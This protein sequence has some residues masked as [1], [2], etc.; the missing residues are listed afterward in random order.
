MAIQRLLRAIFSFFFGFFVISAGAATPPPASSPAPAADS[1]PEC[2]IRSGTPVDWPVAVTDAHGAALPG[3]RVRLSCGSLTTLAV[4]G[5]DGVARL[6]V[7]PGSYR[8]TAEAPGFDAASQPVAV[9]ASPAEPASIRLAVAGA[10]ST[11]EVRADSGY[12]AFS[13]ETGSKS[14]APLIEVPQSISVINTQEMKAR[15][16][17]SV[18]DAVRYTPGVVA[19]EYGVELRYDWMKVRGFTVDQTGV[20]RDGMHWN[21]LAGKLDPYQLESIEI[22]KGPASVLYGEA[23]PGGLINLDTKRPPSEPLHEFRADFGSYDRRQGAL[24]FGGP[25]VGSL[26][27]RLT[28]LVRNSGT[29]I[30]YTPDNRRLAA[31]ALTWRPSD[32]TN[33]TLLGDWQHDK[34]RWS[35]FLPASGTLYH[36][37][38]NGVI[39]VNRFVGE[40]GWEKVIRDQGSIGWMADHSF[41]DGW[42]VHQNYRFQHVNFKGNTVYGVGYDPGSDRLLDRYAYDYPQL[43]DI[44]TVD[45]RATRRFVLGPTEHNFLG[46]YDYT[47]LRTITWGSFAVAPTIDV[48]APVYGAAIPALTPSQYTNLLLEQHGGYLQDQVKVKRRL[49][50]TLG[51]REDW[52][53]DDTVDHLASTSLHQNDSKFTG[54]AGAT[55]LTA[56]GLAPYFSYSTSFQPT[57]GTNYYSQ[58]YKPT[59]GRQEE[60]GL[61]FQPGSWTGFLTASFFNIEQNN[62]LMSDPTNPLNSIQAAQV[63]S[64]GV[65]FEALANVFRGLNLHGG[66]SL[67]A[68]NTGSGWAPQTPRNQASLLADYTASSGLLRGLGGNAGLRFV[69]RSFG[70]TGNSIGI[71]NYTLVDAALRYRWRAAELRVN[72]SNLADRRYIATCTGVSYC[73]Y[74]YARNVTGGLDYRF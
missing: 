53:V 49:I 46:G 16:V 56:F 41:A 69:G 73:G 66:Y 71:P 19:E 12:I 28:A 27:Y 35:Q 55:W 57:T 58:P 17:E 6:R 15:N 51:G 59:Y 21:S 50:L 5:S 25:L 70:A 64:R 54:R 36:D 31:P 29:Q 14:D 47:H 26:S 13:T 45:T 22:L 68:T 8:L 2:S 44:H 4:A 62:V 61:K 30:D 11:V 34:T 67:V 43:N 10:S 3:A 1:V 48:F 42:A 74:G 33:I 39:P 20:F 23:P 9:S 72:A 40:P 24:D 37:N 65:E 38:P 52:A 7:T 63:T 60:T 32:R 18:S